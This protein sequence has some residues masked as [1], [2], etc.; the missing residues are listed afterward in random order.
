M[1]EP[2]GTR[3]LYR[4]P[5]RPD[6]PKERVLMMRS[7]PLRLLAASGVL[8]VVL[9]KPAYAQRFSIG[10]RAGLDFARLELETGSNFDSRIAFS[11]GGF[12][13]Y[14]LSE[15][16]AFQPELSFV[17]KGAGSAVTF[18]GFI[19]ALPPEENPVVTNVH[20][21][22]KLDYLELQ[23]PLTL[24]IPAGSSV[25]MPRVYLGPSLA[26]EVGCETG[27]DVEGEAAPSIPCFTETKKVDF[28]VIVGAGL[29]TRLGD[30]AL[31][32]DLRYNL[33]LRDINAG[34]G[35]AVRNRVVQLLVGYAYYFG[36]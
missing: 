11:V 21:E 12:F 33:G 15:Q 35:G 9:A 7:L 14:R 34:I 28:G 1:D 3:H 31:T 27:A 6:H 25:L 24:L 20:F 8:L 2:S 4:S 13:G 17:M 32:T 5:T 10:G 18:T 26:L 36:E 29:D 22:Y 23:V 16:F 19:E 30:G